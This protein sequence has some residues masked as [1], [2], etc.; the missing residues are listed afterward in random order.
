MVKGMPVPYH[1]TEL[2]DSLINAKLRL[3]GGF[4]ITNDKYIYYC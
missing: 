3:E 2:R 1:M 4:H